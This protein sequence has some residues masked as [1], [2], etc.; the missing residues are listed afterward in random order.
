M[1]L[2]GVLLFN[3]FHLKISTL[4]VVVMLVQK[5]NITRS[6][7]IFQLSSINYIISGV[8]RMCAVAYSAKDVQTRVTIGL[9]VQ[10]DHSRT[11][12]TIRQEEKHWSGFE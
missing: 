2:I 12:S 9:R 6:K 5:I 10:V 3:E 4:S 1:Y 11:P 8:A 7:K